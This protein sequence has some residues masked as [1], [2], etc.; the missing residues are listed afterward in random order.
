MSQSARRG[1][2]LFVLT[3]LLAT[4]PAQA[5]AQENYDD[6][7]AWRTDLSKYIV[8]PDS[9]ADAGR[10]DRVPSINDPKFVSSEEAAEWLGDREPVAVLTLGGEMRAYPVQILLYHDVV[11]DWIGDTPVLVSFCILC[12]SSIAFDRRF[13]GRVLEFGYAGLLNN[14]NLVMYD[15]QTETWWGQIVGEGLVGDYAGERLDM[16]AAPVMSFKDFKASA[17]DGRVLSRDT[18]FDKPYGEGRLVEYDGNPNPIKRVFWKD[19]DVRLSAKER[20]MVI[21]SGDDIVAVPYEALGERRLIT[22][23]VG[24]TEFVVFWGPGTASIYSEVT[25]DGHD[26]GAAVAYYTEI[27]GRRLRFKPAGE[28]RFEDRETGSVWTLAG[29]AIEGPLAGRSLRPAEAAV[30]FWFVWAAYRPETRVVQ[31]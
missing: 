27:D 2:T 4:P 11:N 13:D 28:G 26:V 21:E 20:V 29:D 15:K 17:P 22:T 19:V 5:A 14:S 25:A 10:R 12:G 18:G 30:H 31:R 3:G 7:P 23:D 24:G 6:E 8:H 9:L 1:L 16:I